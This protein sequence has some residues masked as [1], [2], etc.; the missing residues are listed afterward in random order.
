V[1]LCEG[2]I[3]LEGRSSSQPSN[4]DMTLVGIGQCEGRVALEHYRC[5]RCGVLMARQLWG[6]STEQIWMAL[7]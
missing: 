3:E 1:E 2:C 5:R 4:D 7:A 6:E